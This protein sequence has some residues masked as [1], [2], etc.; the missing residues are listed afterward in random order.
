[1]LDGN[2]S[3]VSDTSSWLLYLLQLAFKSL[4]HLLECCYLYQSLCI[5]TSN[6]VLCFILNSGKLIIEYIPTRLMAVF[7]IS[8]STKQEFPNIAYLRYPFIGIELQWMT[9]SSRRDFVSAG[10]TYYG[11]KARLS[12]LVASYDLPEW[13]SLTFLDDCELFK[14]TT[15]YC[16]AKKVSNW[17]GHFS[18]SLATSAL[19]I[20]DE[21]FQAS[22]IMRTTVSDV[23][24]ISFMENL[25][26]TWFCN[27]KCSYSIS[28]QAML[29]ED[30]L[31]V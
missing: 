19:C 1:M 24:R 27:S 8:N 22:W 4:K 31:F 11:E 6:G 14:W 26:S 30:P 5:S 13:K 17:H 15:D 9:A 29:N 3:T 12:E 18:T 2:W 28:S 20:K 21:C 7:L 10:E 23:T 16:R 25:Q